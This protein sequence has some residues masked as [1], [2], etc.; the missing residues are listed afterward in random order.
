MKEG[1]WMIHSNNIK[2]INGEFLRLN[3][4]SIIPLFQ[5]SKISTYYPEGPQFYSYPLIL[6]VNNDFITH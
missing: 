1:T 4:C 3:L 2:R 5:H 6:N